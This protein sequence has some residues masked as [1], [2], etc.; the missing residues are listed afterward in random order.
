MKKIRLLRSSLLRFQTRLFLAAS[1]ILLVL[2]TRDIAVAQSA[3]PSLSAGIGGSDAAHGLLPK[4]DTIYETNYDSNTIEVYSLAGSD[5]GVFGMVSYPTGLTFD[6]A[7][8]LYVSSDDPAGYAIKKFTPNG[9]VSVFANSGLS[10]P[11]ALAFDKA[12][13]LY[14]ANAG[15]NT[16]EKFTP[17]GIGTEFANQDDGLA[18]PIDLVF[19][20]AGNLY[21]SNAFGG[22]TQTGSVEKFTPDGIGSVFADSGFHL[23]YGLA[24]DKTGNLYVSNFRSNTIEKFSPDGTDLGVFASTGVYLPHGM[25]FDRAGNLYVVNN[26]TRTIEKF[27]STG[28]DLGVFAN[29][30][31]APH[32]LAMF[33]RR[34]AIG[35]LD[36]VQAMTR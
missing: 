34:P 32:F 14:V 4:F 33:K 22:P 6:N 8:N 21:V 2:A 10:V 23:A 36:T 5:L 12:G 30:G 24:I 16:I 3:M 1:T 13:N 17:D 26:G 18:K 9:S 15:N 27:S 29:T 11:H 20:T 35:E 19:D 25:I 28:T 7:G 31:G